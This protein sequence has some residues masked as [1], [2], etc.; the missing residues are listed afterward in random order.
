M[1]ER[2]STRTDAIDWMRHLLR[3]EFTN[4]QPIVNDDRMVHLTARRPLSIRCICFDIIYNY[5]RSVVCK[6]SRSVKLEV[7]IIFNPF[8]DIFKPCIYL[9]IIVRL[10]SIFFFLLLENLSRLPRLSGPFLPM[11]FVSNNDISVILIRLLFTFIY[12]CSS[13]F[14]ISCKLSTWK[15][16]ESFSNNI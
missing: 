16:I 3:K 10:S 15:I 11:M 14:N 1:L 6:R 5:N 7:Y 9:P 13:S 12:K 8:F 4:V 2:K